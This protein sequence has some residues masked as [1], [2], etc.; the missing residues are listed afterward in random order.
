M[1]KLSKITKNKSKSPQDPISR[2]LAKDGI[3]STL[4]KKKQLGIIKTL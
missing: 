2:D 4:K 1:K 3:I